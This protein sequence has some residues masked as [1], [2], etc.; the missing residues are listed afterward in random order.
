MMRELLEVLTS[1]VGISGSEHGISEY[2]AGELRESG[3]DVSVDRMGNVRAFLDKGVDKTVCFE[4]HIDEIGLIVKRVCDGGFLKFASIGGV[5]PQTLPASEVV[6]HARGGDR[7]GVITSVPP[8]LQKGE[9]KKAV[10]L[11]DL[12]IDIGGDSEGISIGDRVSFRGRAGEMIGGRFVSKAID[13]RMGVAVLMELA[14]RIKGRELDRNVMFLMTVQE[15]V[16]CRGAEMVRLGDEIESVVVID[17]T[18]A[19]SAVVSEDEGYPID[20]IAVGVGPGLDR[21]ISDRLME[22]AGEDGVVEVCAGNSGTT[23][24]NFQVKNGGVPT[25]LVSAPIRYMHTASEFIDLGTCEK[26]VAILARFVLN[27]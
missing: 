17:V 11:E 18:H 9:A 3:A 23:A 16:G 8:H 6:V 21:G 15:E 7:I 10:K 27:E 2:V 20:K 22:L 26:L 1:K 5:N 19:I 4:A 14:K 13:N 12:Y 24:W 25:G